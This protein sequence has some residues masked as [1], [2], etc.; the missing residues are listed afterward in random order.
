MKIHWAELVVTDGVVDFAGNDPAI[1][2]AMEEFHARDTMRGYYPCSG[3]A[4][5]DGRDAGYEGL[6]AEDVDWE[7]F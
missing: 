1:R 4:L 7:D 5:R 2:E 3:T 6:S